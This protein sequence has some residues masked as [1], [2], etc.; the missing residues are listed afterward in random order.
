MLELL[1]NIIVNNCLYY[2][3]GIHMVPDS[4]KIVPRATNTVVVATGNKAQCCIN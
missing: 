2:L 1:N 4:L 3:M